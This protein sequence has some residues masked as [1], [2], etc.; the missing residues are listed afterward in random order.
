M[1][2]ADAIS[3]TRLRPE[4]RLRTQSEFQAVFRHGRFARGKALN[5]WVRENALITGKSGHPRFGIIVSRKTNKRAVARNGWKRRI[6]EV[7]RCN[8]ACLKPTVSIVVQARQPGVAPAYHI[9]KE[10]LMSL[11]SRAEAIQESSR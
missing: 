3:Q 8:Q 11:L 4:Q 2:H 9:I 10:E 1:N 5:L 7:L 6:R